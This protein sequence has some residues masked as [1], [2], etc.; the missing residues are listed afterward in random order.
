MNGT[1][2]C[3]G[4]SG[5]GFIQQPGG[6]D[7]FFRFC[8]LNL[9]NLQVTFDLVTSTA[10]NLQAKNIVPTAPGQPIEH[11]GSGQNPVGAVKRFDCGWGFIRRDGEDDLFVHYS[12]IAGTGFKS[13]N[14]DDVVEFTIAE[15]ERGLRATNVVVVKSARAVTSQRP[16]P[17]PRPNLESVI[18]ADAPLTDDFEP[19]PLGIY[20]RPKRLVVPEAE[21][22]PTVHIPA[23]PPAAA[24]PELPP[25]SPSELAEIRCIV[26][27]D[28]PA[29]KQRKKL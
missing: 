25:L 20:T 8:Q 28:Y 14:V 27:R 12:D 7:V 5:Y 3:F 21:S 23:P 24:R 16:S 13:L 10:G 15:S 26:K 6:P 17:H 22:E 4:N 11:Y 29:S 2:K 18:I 1:I 19:L 9:R